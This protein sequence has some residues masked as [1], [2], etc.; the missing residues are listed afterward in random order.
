MRVMCEQKQIIVLGISLRYLA[1]KNFRSC[2]IQFCKK[3][4]IDCYRREHTLEWT[5]YKLVFSVDVTG[6]PCCFSFVT[7]MVILNDHF[8]KSCT[9]YGP[10]KR[11]TDIVISYTNAISIFT[12]RSDKKVPKFCV[13][14]SWS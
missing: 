9:D 7:V 1:Y 14:K 5:C 12:S 4:S 8:H 2:K 10:V 13:A 6:R 3:I 11:N